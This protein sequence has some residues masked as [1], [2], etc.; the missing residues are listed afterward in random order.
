[1][2]I[3]HFHSPAKNASYI[4][5]KYEQG[6]IKNALTNSLPAILVVHGRRRAGK[7]ELIEQT[8][9][10]RSILKFEGIQNENQH[11]QIKRCLDQLS[12][13][14]G[15][16]LYREL[17]YSK[18]YQ[19][20]DKLCE[21]LEGHRGEL[22]LYFEEVQWLACYNTEFISELKYFWDNRLK[23]LSGLLLILC[24][25]S[26]SFMINKVLRSKAL[27]NRSLFEVPVKPFN[28]QQ[29]KLFLGSKYSKE[30]VL[31]AFLTI[32]GIPEYLKYLKH[33]SSIL[34]SLCQQSFTSAGFFV[35]EIERIFVS[36]LADKPAYR[37]IVNSIALNRYLTRAQ[38][39]EKS[40]TA[41]GGGLSDL[42]LDLE[43]CGFIEKYTPY[44]SAEN[45]R[46]IR[47]AISDNYL[48]FYYKF[49]APKLR[50]ISKAKYDTCPVSALA[51]QSYRI[52]RGYAFERFCRDV[53]PKIANILGFSS[54]E[55]RCG[56]HFNRDT[57]S[58]GYQIDLVY[59][60]KD[61]VYTICEIKYQ[62]T[63]VGIS[64]FNEVKLKLEKFKPNKDFRVQLVLISA[65]P[66]DRKLAEGAYFD[67]IIGL[68]ELLGD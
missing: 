16:K 12:N 67:R 64:S 15:N 47:Y 56:A 60:R 28:I 20:F 53:E 23:N 14:T 48:Q 30:D 41:E 54:V 35:S 51:M 42:L 31:E 19:F 62:D 27:Y 10:G 61:R 32:G 2:Q 22:T 18:W 49:I 17:E 37:Q 63:P 13:Y 5:R 25:S 6:I 68:E 29:V 44:S 66:V 38:I 26:P 59:E 55:Y 8:L 24:G 57:L 40:A 46:I 52:Y 33:G 3:S 1:M 50:D 9:R 11:Y 45:G 21:V 34:T 39:S 36:S 7:T 43:V 65:G 4:E 58:S